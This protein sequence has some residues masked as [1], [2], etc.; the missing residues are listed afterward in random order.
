MIDE[1]IF[2]KEISVFLD[3]NK[4]D[5]RVKAF[6]NANLNH[7]NYLNFLDSF[8]FNLGLSFFNIEVVSDKNHNKTLGFYPV[9]RIHNDNV[10]DKKVEDIK[11][12]E[13]WLDLKTSS[14][15]LAQEVLNQ[16]MKFND[17][18]SFVNMKYLN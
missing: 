10:F 12:S 3:D 7:Y 8:A 1:R 4:N 17:L 15:L 2:N 18:R 11:L 16:I 14:K 6:K 9:L 5:L 13:E